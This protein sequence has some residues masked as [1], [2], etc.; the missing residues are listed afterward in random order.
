MFPKKKHPFLWGYCH[1]NMEKCGKK[2]AIWLF[3]RK[4]SGCQDPD[5]SW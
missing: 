5:D 2:I 1:K 3:L 4:L